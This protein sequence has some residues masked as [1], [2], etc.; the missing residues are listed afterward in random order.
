L[1][2]NHS[3]RRS[4][5]TFRKDTVEKQHPPL[6]LDGELV[7]QFV[8]IFP[9]VTELGLQD[10]RDLGPFIIGLKEAFF[11]IYRIGKTIC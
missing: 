9:K 6:I 7:W 5:K 8:K 11:G 2:P 3:L 10:W 4:K 1:P